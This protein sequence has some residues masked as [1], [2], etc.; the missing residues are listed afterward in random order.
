MSFVRPEAQAALWRWREVLAAA[1]LGSLGLYWM[2]QEGTF[3]GYVGMFLVLLA[4]SLCWVGVPRGLVRSNGGE[5]PGMVSV[6]EGQ[7]SYFGPLTGGV[8]DLDALSRL[9]LDTTGHPH[10]WVLVVPGQESL[11]VPINAAGADTL[12]DA[13]QALPGVRAT[14]LASA[15]QHSD[16]HHIVWRRPRT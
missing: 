1:A 7:V 8:V 4:V 14:A 6:T 3:L 2:F 13:L 9:D 5:G 12:F 15:L 10:H 16:G 11:Y